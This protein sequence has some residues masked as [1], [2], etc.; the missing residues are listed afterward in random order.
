MSVSAPLQSAVPG[1]TKF[2]LPESGLRRDKLLFFSLLYCDGRAYVYFRLPSLFI[3]LFSPSQLCGCLPC[4]P[5]C[6]FLPSQLWDGWLTHPGVFLLDAIN[7]SPLP[8]AHLSQSIFV[9]SSIQQ[10]QE[11]GDSQDLGWHVFPFISSVGRVKSSFSPF[12][13]GQHRGPLPLQAILE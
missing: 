1:A 7:C 10:H 12:P 2:C 13:T 4:Q 8:S 6:F 5:V 11:G 3:K 9:Y